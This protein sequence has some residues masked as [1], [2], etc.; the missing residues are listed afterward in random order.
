MGEC[1]DI[2]NIRCF[3]PDNTADKLYISSS[4]EPSLEHI[5]DSARGHFG[6]HLTISDITIEAEHIHTRCLGYGSYDPGDWEDFLVVR[7]HPSAG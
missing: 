7:R 4:L 1:R 6:A 2:H 3:D 5:L